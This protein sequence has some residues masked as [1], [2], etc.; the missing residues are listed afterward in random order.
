[1]KEGKKRNIKKS[2]EENW[3]KNQKWEK[4]AKGPVFMGL[5]LGNLVND[6]HKGI[7]ILKTIFIK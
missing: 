3:K 2:N 1:M 5:D 4:N 6:F 7:Y